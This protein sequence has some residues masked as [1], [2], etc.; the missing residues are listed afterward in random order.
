MQNLA[1]KKKRKIRRFYGFGLVWQHCK[2]AR[3]TANVFR[4]KNKFEESEQNV[5]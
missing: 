3:C 2:N 5:N 1:N 4:L